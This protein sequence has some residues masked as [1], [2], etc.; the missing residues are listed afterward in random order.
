LKIR[1][2]VESTY[3]SLIRDVGDGDG[4]EGEANKGEG[5]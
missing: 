4:G 3:K 5:R 1:V 2:V